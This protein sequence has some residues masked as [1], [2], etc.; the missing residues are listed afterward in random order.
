MISLVML[1]LIQMVAWA[2]PD[3]A[4]LTLVIWEIS[5]EISSEICLAAEQEV[6][7]QTVR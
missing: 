6:V 2:E 4:D 5:L 1:H 3:L 7:S